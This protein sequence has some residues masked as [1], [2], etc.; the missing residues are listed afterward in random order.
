M[1]PAF[2]EARNEITSAISSTWAAR[3]K[4]VVAPIAS[5]SSA[6]CTAVSWTLLSDLPIQTLEQCQQILNIYRHRWLVEELH[7]AMKT[8]LKLGQQ[9]TWL[10]RF[11]SGTMALRIGGSDD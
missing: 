4:M 10:T 2:G 11:L 8:G 9:H 1:Y 7:K 5:V 3:P 6:G